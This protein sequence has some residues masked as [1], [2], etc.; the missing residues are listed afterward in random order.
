MHTALT[1]YQDVV[2]RHGSLAPEISGPRCVRDP[3]TAART[4]MLPRLSWV[5]RQRHGVR[6]PSV[7]AL[8][9]I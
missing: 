6:G 3:F 2:L 9:S 8:A 1:H 5:L 4:T 7:L